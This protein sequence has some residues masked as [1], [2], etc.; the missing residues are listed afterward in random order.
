[1][2]YYCCGNLGDHMN[3]IC[4]FR[5]SHRKE[6]DKRIT[7][8]LF[9]S[10]R[11][12]GVKEIYYSG[13]K[14][15]KLESNILEVE[16]RWGK[17]IR[18]LNYVDKPQSFLKRLK[19]SHLLVHL[20]MYGVPYKDILPSLTKET[21]DLCII[22]GSEKV[23][24]WVYSIAD[25]NVAIGNQPHSEITAF[26]ILLYELKGYKLYEPNNGELK[27]IPQERGKKVVKNEK[28]K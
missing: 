23:P 16:K 21:H 20:T 5:L 26:T 17:S 4:L 18:I 6:R 11:V 14:D 7:T 2:F 15:E 27:I 24:S 13:D 1:M 8:H 10:A 9:L 19:K 3:D 12:L 22:V 25:Y 28:R